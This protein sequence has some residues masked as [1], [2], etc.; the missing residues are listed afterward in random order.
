MKYTIIS[1]ELFHFHPH[2]AKSEY[3]EI[4]IF[5]NFFAVQQKVQNKKNVFAVLPAKTFFLLINH[6]NLKG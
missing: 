3:C 4:S 5:N 2:K 6:C 1:V